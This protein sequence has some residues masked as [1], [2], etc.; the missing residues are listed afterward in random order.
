MSQEE[1]NLSA[2]NHA[3]SR[4]SLE[5]I[6]PS[7]EEAVAEGLEKLGVREDQVDIQVLDEGSKGVFGLGTRQARVRITFRLDAEPDQILEFER[8]DAELEAEV[9]EEQEEAGE[10]PGEV[11]PDSPQAEIYMGYAE[12]DIKEEALHI[13]RE[14]VV[15]L[16]DRMHVNAEVN[17]Y[18]AEPDDAHSRSPVWVDVNGNDL[19]VLIGRHA[20]TLN[21]LQYITSLIVNK[22]L[23]RSV[24]LVVDVQGYRARRR[25]EVARLA[26]QMA[27]QAVM[28]GRRQYL[29]PMPADVRRL[30]HIELRKDDRVTTRSIGEDPRRKVTITPVE[31]EE[32][33]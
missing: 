2:M 16:L 7:V 32:D 6:A 26:R 17:S 28:T 13:A 19:S 10:E 4:T 20:E 14:T 8:E 12:L 31:T 18:Y 30:V 9:D 29:E 5:V 25:E 15:D 23:G 24:P 33:E 21:A 22:E 3:T 1:G 11:E 27:D